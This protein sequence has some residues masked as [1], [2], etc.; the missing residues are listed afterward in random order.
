MSR[1]RSIYIYTHT[2]QILCFDFYHFFGP[3]KSFSCLFFMN[4]SDMWYPTTGSSSS[5]SHESLSGPEAATGGN[6]LPTDR[7][8]STFDGTLDEGMESRAFLFWHVEN[9]YGLK[10]SQPGSF[11]RMDIGESTYVLIDQV[12][13]IYSWLLSINKELDFLAYKGLTRSVLR[14]C[15]W[16]PPCKVHLPW[17]W[18]DENPSNSRVTEGWYPTWCDVVTW[19]CCFV[20]NDWQ[21]SGWQ[22]Y[23]FF[24]AF[25]TWRLM[26]KAF[27]WM[28]EWQVLETLPE[29]DGYTWHTWYTCLCFG[30]SS[31]CYEC[32]EWRKAKRPFPVWQVT[33]WYWT[34]SCLGNENR[35]V[36]P[37]PKECILHHAE[38]RSCFN[39][40]GCFC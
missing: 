36:G 9:I 35:N 7:E 15:C 40:M 24:P 8:R 12:G 28:L 39:G 20:Q 13:Y 22:M 17:N 31:A 29:D 14:W 4:R 3:Q 11:W 23:E 37:I 33:P 38:E 30:V 5:S 21:V 18:D 25:C 19:V 1:R 34:S 32:Y 27:H 6:R 26:I 16:A 10:K 2:L